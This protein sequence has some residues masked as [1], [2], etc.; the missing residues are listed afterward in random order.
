ML[1]VREIKDVMKMKTSGRVWPG[2]EEVV[3]GVGAHFLDDVCKWQEPAS[4]KFL[5]LALCTL[6]KCPLVF[7]V[8]TTEIL[9][10]VKGKRE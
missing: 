2:W 9:Q 10:K 7:C 3:I 4:S 5:T 6:P 1:K 8:T